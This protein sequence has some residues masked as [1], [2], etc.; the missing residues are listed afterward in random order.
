MSERANAAPTVFAAADP[1]SG[2]APLTV[3]FEADAFDA[4]GPES[5]ITYLWDFG[6][7]GAAQFGANASHTYRTPGTYTATVTATD[8]DGAFDT[9]E[10][11][12]VVDGPP[13]NQ[14]PTVQIAATPRSGAAPLPV[15][16]SRRRAIRRVS[17]S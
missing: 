1:T 5:E 17:S 13:A 15:Q 7:E 16:F 6:D 8:A 10:M 9:E 11:T 4:D 3:K 2:R 14:P 12:I